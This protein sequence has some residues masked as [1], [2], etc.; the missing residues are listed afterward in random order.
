MRRVV[1][2]RVRVISQ[3]DAD[4]GQLGP[5]LVQ[6]AADERAGVR[7]DGEPAVLVRIGVLAD[8]LTAADD[9]IEG[10][11]YQAP[12]G[13]ALAPR[14]S[15][16]AA[17]SRPWPAGSP[18][19]GTESR[20]GPAGHGLREASAPASS[21]RHWRPSSTARS[22]LRACGTA[23]GSSRWSPGTAR[24][25]C[26]DP[27]PHQSSLPISEDLLHLFPPMPLRPAPPCPAAS[28]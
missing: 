25:R 24:R 12:V 28:T 9:V 4:C 20:S 18:S 8:A 5:D 2:E 7:V 1:G 26:P 23:R 6:V 19:S 15:A 14:L 10:D 16:A 3:L 27:E 13:G 11:V 21:S 22:H 17:P